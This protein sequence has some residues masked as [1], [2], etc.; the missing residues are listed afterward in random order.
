MRKKK[1]RWKSVHRL[2]QVEDRLSGVEDKVYV[3]KYTD[4]KKRKKP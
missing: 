2:N 4:E 1:N 3:L